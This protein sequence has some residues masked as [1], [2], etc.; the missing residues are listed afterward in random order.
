MTADLLERRPFC[1]IQKGGRRLGGG[2]SIDCRDARLGFRMV[3]QD[4]HAGLGGAANLVEDHRKRACIASCLVHETG[5]IGIGG[6]FGL[7]RIARLQY[8]FRRNH[9]G[10]PADEVAEQHAEQERQAGPLQHRLGSVPMND[11]ADFVRDHSG[12]LVCVAGF[13]DQPSENIDLS[14]RQRDGVGF[15]TPHHLGTQG[16]WQ[17]G[18]HLKPAYDLFKRCT[19]GHFRCGL[20]AIEGRARVARVEH[21]AN[22]D[23]D[24]AA[25][26]ALDRRR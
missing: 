5:A 8:G 19:P 20:A 17:S 24:G 9:D 26:P 22:L 2:Q 21:A 10:A 12:D 23:V 1:R 7:A 4:F 11:M 14:A 16:E 18:G 15:V 6:R 13:V 3:Q 25:Q